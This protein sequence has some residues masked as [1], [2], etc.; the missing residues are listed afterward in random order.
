MLWHAIEHIE[1]RAA[2]PNEIVHDFILDDD[3]HGFVAGGI[4][5][6]NSEVLRRYIPHTRNQMQVHNPH[7]NTMPD[8]MPGHDYHIDF[9]HSDPFAI[10]P[11]GEA[12][13]AGPSY[14]SL[15]NIDLSM[16]LEADVL[17]EELDSQMAYFLGFPEYMAHRNKL[18]DMV[19]P[20]KK[21]VEL[22]ARRY[23]NMVKGETHLYEPS[24]NLHAE[25]DAIVR[26]AKGM[27]SPVKIV[28][29]GLGGESSLNAFM[30]LGDMYK[31]LLIEVDTET[32]NIAQRMVNR[33][34]GRFQ[35][36]VE[37]SRSATAASYGSIKSLESEGK[38][39]N[40]ANAYSWFD[41]FKILSDVAPY[42]DSYQMAEAIVDQQIASGNLGDR[43]SEYY[44]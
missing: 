8:W 10:I 18:I 16:P 32:G 23:G 7:R 12:R 33:D 2:N 36:E 28:P 9:Q 17:G 24:I 30:V 31:G 25:A 6:H 14:E 3:F 20:V 41:R 29:M 40:L 34:V 35:A 39:M 21:D 11:L 5:A 15:H 38:A 42:S 26:D 44:I 19:E 22:A 27:K 4:I 37:N 1:V 43:V 13:L